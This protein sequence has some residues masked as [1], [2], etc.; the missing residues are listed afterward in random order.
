M[1]LEKNVAFVRSRLSNQTIVAATKYVEADVIREL[2]QLG[3]A[4]IGENLAQ[5]LLRKQAALADLPIRW[6]FLGHLQ[7]NKVKTIANRI[8]CLHSLDS[9]RLAAELQKWRNDPLDCFVEVHISPEPS[10]TGVLPQDVEKFVEELADYDKIRV[11]GLMGMAED[12]EDLAAIEAAFRGL[13]A[14]RDRLASRPNPKAPCRFLSMGMS[15]DYEIAVRCGA[16]HVRLGSILFRN[17]G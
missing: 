1:N 11:V 15:H 2:F 10:K 6:H 13:G 17:E 4:D 9:L 5:S 8:V 12:T 16:T 7:T 14:L 3:I